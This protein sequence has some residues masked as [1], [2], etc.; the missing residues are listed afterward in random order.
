MKSL[1]HIYEN[2]IDDGNIIRTIYKAMSGKRKTKS[3]KKLRYFE[4]WIKPK[5]ETKFLRKSVS[6]YAKKKTRNERVNNIEKSY[7]LSGRK[8]HPAG[9][10]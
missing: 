10:N 1:S 3:I 4:E 9:R 7:L 2:I 6:N 8:R 5:I